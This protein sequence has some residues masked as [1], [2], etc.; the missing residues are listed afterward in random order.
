MLPDEA[1]QILECATPIVYDPDGTVKGTAKINNALAPS[2]DP[3][4]FMVWAED[5]S[6]G[7]TDDT[8][9]IKIWY[10]VD[11]DEVVVYDNGIDQ[12]ISQG[13]VKIKTK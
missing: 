2:D 12:V 5:L 3:Y 1:C 11:G 7:A 6:P 9:R 8:F 4:D 13:K 10:E